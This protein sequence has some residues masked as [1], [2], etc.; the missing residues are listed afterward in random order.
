MYLLPK[1]M[2]LDTKRLSFQNDTVTVRYSYKI[3]KALCDRIHISE[4]YMTYVHQIYNPFLRN[5]SI[6]L[7]KQC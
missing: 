5:C 3:R 7:I 4:V 2:T 6:K 1:L